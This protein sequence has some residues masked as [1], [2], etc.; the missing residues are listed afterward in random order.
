LFDLY[1]TAE[2]EAAYKLLQNDA[3]NKKHYKA[4]KKALSFLAAN[5]RHKSLQTHEFDSLKG[6]TG[7]KVFKAY[8][9]QNTPAAYRIFWHHG[10][11]EGSITVLAIT[12]HP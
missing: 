8:A 2:A 5:P 12:P 1:W 3:S 7:E 9:E 4:V 10:P 6:L 11:S